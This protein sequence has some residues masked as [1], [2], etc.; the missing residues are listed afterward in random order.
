MNVTVGF[1]VVRACLSLCVCKPLFALCWK[2]SFTSFH[3]PHTATSHTPHLTLTHTSPHTAR[4]VPDD[5][6]WCSDPTFLLEVLVAAL[7][8]R[9]FQREVVNAMPL[10]PTEQL[11]FD[12]NKV[13]S[14]NYTGTL[15]CTCCN[16]TIF[17][18]CFKRFLMCLSSWV[19]VHSAPHIIYNA[20]C[21][22]ECTTMC[23]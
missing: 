16:W 20:R 18:F 11:L 13:P 3:A 2:P 5:P 9:R 22:M 12:E 10:Y 1:L 19:V 4:L 21:I 6:Q 7:Q 8:K 23:H 15:T 14:V 17:Y